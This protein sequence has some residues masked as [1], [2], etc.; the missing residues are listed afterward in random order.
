MSFEEPTYEEY[1][2]ATTFARVRYK[3]GLIITILCWLCLLFIIYYMV[4]NGEALASNP[5]MYGAEKQNVECVCIYNSGFE[6]FRVN[7]TT[8]TPLSGG[9]FG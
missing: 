1:R 2:V 7:A 5:L 4:V 9:G 6:S 8:I 3:Y